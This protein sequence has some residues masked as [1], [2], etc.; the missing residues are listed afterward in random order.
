MQ[1]AQFMRM[2]RL[3]WRRV[4][5]MWMIQVMRVH[6]RMLVRIMIV[7]CLCLLLCMIVR[8]RMGRV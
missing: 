6:V 5:I 8:L 4:C 7:M 1:L 2:Q 3:S